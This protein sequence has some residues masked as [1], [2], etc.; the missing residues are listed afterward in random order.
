MLQ[1]KVWRMMWVSLVMALNLSCCA[2]DP[3]E[4]Y[5]VGGDRLGETLTEW[6]ANNPDLDICRNKTHER[7]ERA[8]VD[9]DVVYCVPRPGADG[10]P[11]SFAG[12]TLLAETA[13]FYKGSLFKIEITLRNKTGLAD[14]MNFLRARLGT[15][16][17]RG[18]TPF[19]D[20]FGFRFEQFTWIWRNKVSTAQLTLSNTPDDS[21]Q[22][23]FTLDSVNNNVT[24]SKQE[25]AAFKRLK[26]TPPRAS[27][28][29]LISLL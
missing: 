17:G 19:R 13:W 22:I 5:A 12:A 28:Y 10:A 14:V 24:E 15:Q 25:V 11:L 9:H 18:R 20:G 23:I 7:G 1:A 26:E 3:S 21:P 6:K 2:Q 29:T 8:S 4:P 16:T 27:P